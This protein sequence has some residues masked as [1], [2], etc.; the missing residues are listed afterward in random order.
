MVGVVCPCPCVSSALLTPKLML[1]CFVKK[2][3]YFDKLL[4]TGVE[5]VGERRK[6]KTSQLG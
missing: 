5:C 2:Y 6:I 3:L 4:Q 1:K